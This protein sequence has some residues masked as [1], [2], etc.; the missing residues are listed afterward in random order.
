[1]APDLEPE[2]Q[3]G[4]ADAAPGKGR[5][6]ISAVLDKTRRTGTQGADGSGEITGR[7]ETGGL[8]IS[9]LM[10]SPDPD[11][12]NGIKPA[13]TGRENLVYRGSTG[14]Q[15]LSMLSEYAIDLLIFDEHLPDMTGRQ[16]IEKVVTAHPMINTVIASPRSHQDFHDLY[17]G[18]G[19]LMQVP[20]RPGRNII[21]PIFQR[22]TRIGVL[23]DKTAPG[24]EEQ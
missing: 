16:F 5:G 6:R 23:Q 8:M 20:V 19:V 15:A 22:L 7:T 3:I 9:T 24:K 2:L 14:Q 1:M 4:Q 11:F 13:L 10:V 17:E 21:D 12:F 18:F